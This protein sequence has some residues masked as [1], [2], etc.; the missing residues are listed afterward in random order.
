M[1]TWCK[2]SACILRRVWC[3]SANGPSL[4]PAGAVALPPPDLAP[5]YRIE[6]TAYQAG[7]EI[8][9]VMVLQEE[10]DRHLRLERKP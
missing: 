10:G 5:R 3:V 8:N 7:D 6:T 4:S 9:M 2:G 1:P